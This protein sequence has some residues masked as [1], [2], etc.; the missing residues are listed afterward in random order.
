M[1]FNPDKNKQAQEAVFLKKQ[2]KADHDPLLLINM[3]VYWVA[4]Q[5]HLG[6][7][8]DEKLNFEHYIKKKILKVSHGIRVIH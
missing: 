2:L 7:F 8:L 6:L 4:V 5:K 3:P 1:S